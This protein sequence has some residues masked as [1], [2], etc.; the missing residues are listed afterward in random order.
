MRLIFKIEIVEEGHRRRRILVSV[1]DR[2]LEPM[3]ILLTF[4]TSAC[5]SSL[6]PQA[7]RL[8]PRF[9]NREGK[10]IKLGTFRERVCCGS[11]RRSHKQAR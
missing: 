9:Q 4:Y 10:S 3:E 6:R 11:N 7:C 2:D 8:R 1:S 5:I